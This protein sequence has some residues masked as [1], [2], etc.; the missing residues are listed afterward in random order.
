MKVL[1]PDYHQSIEC[2][3]KRVEEMVLA[4]HAFQRSHR[5]SRDTHA[6]LEYIARLSHQPDLRARLTD[7]SDS[8][9]YRPSCHFMLI[10][11]GLLPVVSVLARRAEAVIILLLGVC[12][13]PK[14]ANRSLAELVAEHFR[15]DRFQVYWRHLQLHSVDCAKCHWL[16]ASLGHIRL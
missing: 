12:F 6:S 7:S 4:M 2:I 14:G 16:P 5:P 11:V 13:V 9:A 10:L 3:S 1:S 8:P 15:G